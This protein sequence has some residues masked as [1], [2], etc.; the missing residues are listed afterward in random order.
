MVLDIFSKVK[1]E[2][3]KPEILVDFREKN[4]LVPSELMKIGC[5][6]KFVQLDI[7]DYLV[8]NKVIERKTLSDLQSSIINKRIFSQID[9]L[10]SQKSP[11]IM[12]ELS[13]NWNLSENAFRGFVLS[14]IS[15]KIPVI[16]SQN[17]E[18]TAK[19][20]FLLSQDK[21]S[22]DFSFRPYKKLEKK[23]DLV[24]YV[25]E[26]F[27]G[28]GPATAKKLLDKFGSI[29][30]IINAPENELEKILGKKAAI[31]LSLLR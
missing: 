1:K 19:Y 10:K 24:R 6:I 30:N 18:D 17:E 27:P 26:G 13:S 3:P 8:S 5:N 14:T 12:I 7:G 31:F 28:I 20:I 16:I 2:K 4:S 9:K 22:K 21:K 25:L 11:F 29:K 15:E 23:E